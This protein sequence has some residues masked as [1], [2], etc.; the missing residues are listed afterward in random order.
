MITKLKQLINDNTVGQ[1]NNPVLTALRDL[2]L[3]SNDT[4]FTQQVEISKRLKHFFANDQSK[5]Q[6]LKSLLIIVGDY[7]Q[8][9]RNFYIKLK[10]LLLVHIIIS[11]QVARAEFSKM[12]INTKLIIN[13]KSQEDIENLHGQLCQ[14]YYCYIYKLAAQTTLINEEFN[15]PQDDL[16]IYFTLSNQC[17]IGMNMQQL[18]ERINQDHE[19]NHVMAHLVKFLYFDIQDIYIFILKDVKY[20]IEKNPT[21]I[22]NRQQLLELYKECQSLQTK[23]LSF[24]KFNRFFPHFN[25]IMPPHSIQIKASVL[26]SII[27]E[28]PLIKQSSIKSGSHEI[29]EPLSVK[30]SDRKFQEYNRPFSPK[31]KM[32]Q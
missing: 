18:I 11:S 16:M 31:Q 25:Q 7:L 22:G 1:T 2:K 6:F 19:P 15:K 21:L 14:S 12:I 29:R 23:M 9:E 28:K 8:Q 20:L 27:E 13:I 32:N 30:N 10:M 17:Y 5:S 24:Y 26:N 3:N 4:Q